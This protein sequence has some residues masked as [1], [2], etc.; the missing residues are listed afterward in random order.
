MLCPLL[1]NLVHYHGDS[2]GDRLPV[3]SQALQGQPRKGLALR[4]PAVLRTWPGS[5]FSCGID[6]RLH[7]T[8]F[9]LL[10]V[11]EGMFLGVSSPARRVAI[12]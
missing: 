6:S 4:F 2:Q 12:L 10:L 9:L 5:G 1:N 7:R 8:V 3:M 11:A